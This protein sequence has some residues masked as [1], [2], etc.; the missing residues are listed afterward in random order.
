MRSRSRS[1]SPPSCC[2]SS[3]LPSAA[4]SMETE[5]RGSAWES[6]SRKNQL[7]RIKKLGCFVCIRI[8]TGRSGLPVQSKR[9]LTQIPPHFLLRYSICTSAVVAI[10]QGYEVQSGSYQS[11]FNGFLLSLPATSSPCRHQLP[12]KVGV[13]VGKINLY[14]LTS[15]LAHGTLN[16]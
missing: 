15:Y 7:E 10:G 4:L 9:V 14:E 8:Q 1:P 6:V 5:G 16:F 2:N 13:A 11:C 3:L 12:P